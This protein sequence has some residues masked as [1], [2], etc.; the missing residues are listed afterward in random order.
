MP[1]IICQVTKFVKQEVPK[2][3]E[4]KKQK[5]RRKQGEQEKRYTEKLMEH[6][7]SM[8]KQQEEPQIHVYL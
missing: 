2:P 6:S 7:T 5:A 1:F 8:Q 4:T 3:T